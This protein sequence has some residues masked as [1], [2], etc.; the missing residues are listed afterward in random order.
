MPAWVD[1]GFHEYA[2]RFPPHC[3][4]ELVEVAAARRGKGADLT[5]VAGDECERLTAKLPVRAH[6]IALER[7]GRTLSTEQIA[8]HLKTWL[9]QEDAVAF[10]VGGPEGLAPACVAR[11][12]A[13][14]SLS[15]LTLPH[16]LVRV[17]LAEQL[18]RAYS[19]V[20]NLPYHRGARDD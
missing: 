1:A 14:W 7:T 6:L 5:R 20:H 12:H 8:A 3:R 13:V 17:L 10:L 19:L 2:Q 9:V 11:A 16:P 18:Y 4:L 15:A